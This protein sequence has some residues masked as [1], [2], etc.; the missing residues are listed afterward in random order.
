MRAI[1]LTASEV[2]GPP[3]L[4]R[5]KRATGPTASE[6]L[7]TL[8][9]SRERSERPAYPRARRAIDVAWARAA[10]IRARGEGRFHRPQTGPGWRVRDAPGPTETASTEV[11]MTIARRG[12]ARAKRAKR[13]TG[14]TASEA[15]GPPSLAQA[16]WATDLAASPREPPRAIFPTASEPSDRPN[17]ERSKRPPLSHTNQES[18]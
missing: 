11:R 5:A 10:S 13:A 3:Y 7:A 1:D 4:T 9:L 2:G 14:I 12:R 15:I 6:A 17:R 18:D 16:K 8:P